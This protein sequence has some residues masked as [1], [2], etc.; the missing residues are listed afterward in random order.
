[1]AKVF[2]YNRKYS[3]DAHLGL[4]DAAKQLLRALYGPN[5]QFD[6]PCDISNQTMMQFK[7]GVV[8]RIPKDTHRYIKKMEP[9]RNEDFEE[10]ELKLCGS[11]L[12]GMAQHAWTKGVKI[13][14]TEA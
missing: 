12:Y 9:R 6:V 2:S 10:S 3:D 1:M 4:K 7:T 13:L 5:A 11:R 8:V 14:Y